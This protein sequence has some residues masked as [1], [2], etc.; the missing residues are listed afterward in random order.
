[1]GFYEIVKFLIEKKNMNINEKNNY[2]FTALHLSC[3]Y[4]KVE[5]SNYLIEKGGDLNLKNEN[6]RTPLFYFKNKK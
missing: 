4:G 5:I 1:M 6:D 2:G 3:K